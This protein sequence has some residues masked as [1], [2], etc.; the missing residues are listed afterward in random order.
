MNLRFEVVW[1]Q[2]P[3]FGEGLWNTVWLCTLTM[4]LSLM[5]GILFLLPLLSRRAVLRIP[6]KIFVEAGRAIPFLM[7]I[8]LVFYGLPVFGIILSRW[9]TAIVSLVLYNTAYMAEILH[10]A[11]INLPR[12]QIEAARAFGYT[13]FKLLRRIVLPQI[14][15]TASPVLGNQLIQVIKDSA[16][17][18]VI[19]IPEITH[20]AQT[21]QAMYFV[22][23]ES[24]IFAALLYWV[25]CL[26]I[27]AGVKQVE[28]M[29]AVYARA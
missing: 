18:T 22:P 19:T 15:I 28:R 11:W 25:L 4:I 13:G 26:V 14:L 21:V 9:T 17:L 1:E 23:F 5:T 16:F 27:E 29:R 12:G 24:F 3:A 8:Y 7:L 10:S 6:A 20:A 2:L